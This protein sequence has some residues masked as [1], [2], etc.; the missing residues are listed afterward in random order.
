MPKSKRNKQVDLSKTRQKGLEGKKNLYRKI[1]ENVDTYAHVFVFSVADMRNTKMK[2]LREQWKHSRFFIGKNKVMAMALGRSPEEEYK[3][4]LHKVGQMLKG[5]RGLLFT[6]QSIDECAKWFESFSEGD[7]ARSG[8]VATEDVTLYEGP[9]QQFP[10]SLEAYLRQLGL[11]TTLKKSMGIDQN[12]G[13]IHLI[14]DYVVC[15][16]GDRLSPETARILKL[17]GY[18]MAEFRVKLE[19]VW[20]QDGSFVDFQSGLQDSEAKEN[21]SESKHSCTSEKISL[22]DDPVVHEKTQ[23]LK[24]VENIEECKKLSMDPTS[25]DDVIAMIVDVSEEPK[26][27]KRKGGPAKKAKTMNKKE[28]QKDNEEN[29]SEKEKSDI[30]KITEEKLLE[31]AEKPKKFSPRVTRARAAATK[32]TLHLNLWKTKQGKEK[33]KLL[34]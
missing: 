34:Y 1:Q 3:S 24:S 11:P 15:R 27:K 31:S 5:E 7:Y 2:N 10:H 30:L 19:C 23:D 25:K 12:G 8:N 18:E 21:I 16:S 13:V 26:P 20:S 9:L 29:Y 6:N 17:L 14:Q 28:I 22:I 32:K 4:N 33:C